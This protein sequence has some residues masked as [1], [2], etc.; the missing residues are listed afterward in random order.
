MEASRFSSRTTVS[1][2]RSTHSAIAP[3]QVVSA[4]PVPAGKAHIVVSLT[5]GKR[6][7][8]GN[9]ASFAIRKAHPGAATLQ[10]NGKPEGSA[11]FANVSGG[12]S[13]TLDVGS[14]L[15]SAVSADYQSPNRFTGKIEAVTI[16][17]Q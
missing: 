4:D 14:D 13:E 16:Q 7:Q 17:L 6:D 1:C 3:G 15:G 5:Q 10:I 8:D 9:S 12:A 2:T 11:Q